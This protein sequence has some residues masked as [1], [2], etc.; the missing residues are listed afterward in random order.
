MVDDNLRA[1]IMAAIESTNGG[2]TTDDVGQPS[3]N[4]DTSARD[5]GGDE[6]QREDTRARDELG[7]FTKAEEAKAD[8]KPA[9]KAGQKR[10]T[11]TLKEKPAEPVKPAEQTTQQPKPEDQQRVAPPAQWKGDA[12]TR[13]ERLPPPVQREIADFLKTQSE[14]SER[15]TPIMR[16]LEPARE[17]LTREGNGDF[18]AGVQQ[19]LNIS[20]WASG[21]PLDFVSAFIRQRGLN[22][23]AIAA[24]LGL[25]AAPGQPGSQ[26]QTAQPQF[27]PPEITQRLTQL[28]QGIKSQ[29]DAATQSEIEAF[30]N[31][32]A[33]PY[34]ADV[35]DEMIAHLNAMRAA[36]QR[37]NLQ[38][39]YD[40]AVWANPATRAQLLAAQQ[41]A[42]VQ[43][44]PA[45]VA[46]ARAARS[47]NLNG[48]PAPGAS[49]APDPKDEGLRSTIARQVYASLGGSRI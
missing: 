27:I 19:L 2:G 7:R 18:T 33:H 21:Q 20:Q 32:P 28:E 9:E 16:A 6:G 38:Q 11:L 39:A 46:A 26:P 41:P 42:T 44:D 1:D 49:G 23:Q 8:D 30:V 37:P 36:G 35:Q 40:R 25:Q 29:R 4:A 43:P 12:K 34:V 15:A 3:G 22:L 31:D 45:V 17:M 13:W 5:L 10:E 14:V 24:K 48:S 47:A